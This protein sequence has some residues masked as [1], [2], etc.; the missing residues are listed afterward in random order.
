MPITG[1]VV[2]VGSWLES[3]G[4]TSEGCKTHEI[5]VLWS[6]LLEK[7]VGS[8]VRGVTTSSEDN[9]SVLGMLLHQPTFR[10]SEYHTNRFAIMLIL[11]ASNLLALLDELGDF[12][13]LENLDAFG[14]LLRKVFQLQGQRR[15]CYAKPC[16]PTFSINA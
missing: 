9:S 8:E 14:R 12:G 15:Q 2:S 5:V 6:V 10:I 3:A 7:R 1:T 16:S 11:D 13:L 4:D